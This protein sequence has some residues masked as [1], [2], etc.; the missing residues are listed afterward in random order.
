MAPT[1]AMADQ[2]AASVPAGDHKAFIKK[3]DAFNY[4]QADPDGARCPIGSHIRRSNPR[5]SH[6]VQR[7][8]NAHRLV[9]RRGMPYGPIY[10]PADPSDKDI[11]RG[12]LGNFL[13]AS[14]PVQFEVLQRDWINMGLQDPRV[15]GTNDPLVGDNDGRSTEFR[16]TTSAGKPVVTRRLPSFAFTQGGAYH[17][18]P[19][20]PALR[21]IGAAGWR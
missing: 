15:T 7:G 4:R 5:D 21:W 3:F 8:T 12:L 17:F 9:V 11:P 2:L 18:I 1:Q 13:C 10:N 6:I 19:S 20:I 14:I 16:W